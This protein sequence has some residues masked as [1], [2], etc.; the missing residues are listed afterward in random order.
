M[1][2]YTRVVKGQSHQI[3]GL[4]HKCTSVLK[5]KSGPPPISDLLKDIDNEW[6]THPNDSFSKLCSKMEHCDAKIAT[7]SLQKDETIFRGK[8]TDFVALILHAF[9]TQSIPESPSWRRCTPRAL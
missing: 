9:K 5:N 2:S 1:S 6:E 3:S 7:L 8:F 4:I